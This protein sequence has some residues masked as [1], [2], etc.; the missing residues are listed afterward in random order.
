MARRWS[1]RTLY[2]DGTVDT[3]LRRQSIHVFPMSV[4]HTH[5]R[6]TLVFSRTATGDTPDDAVGCAMELHADLYALLTS[7]E[8]HCQ[9]RSGA[10]AGSA[11]GY[12]ELFAPSPGRQLPLRPA[13]Q[14]ARPHIYA[15]PCLRCTSGFAAS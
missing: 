5:Q 4:P 12:Q 9:S 14:L 6:C 10:D 15:S 11:R 3:I 13:D 8:S 1:S 2:R 7:A